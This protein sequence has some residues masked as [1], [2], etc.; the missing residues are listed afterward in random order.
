MPWDVS[1]VEKHIKGL[2]DKQKAKWCRIANSVLKTC[3]ADNGKDC[4]GTAVRV[5]N[6][7]FDKGGKRAK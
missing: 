4:D 7:S 6:S 3:I 5:A 1:G 2:T